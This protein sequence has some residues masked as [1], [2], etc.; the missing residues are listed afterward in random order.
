[1]ITD[2]RA[3]QVA[4]E[5][6]MNPN[7][8]RQMLEHSRS[9]GPAIMERMRRYDRLVGGRRN[10]RNQDDQETSGRISKAEKGDSMPG[11]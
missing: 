9:E 8:A 7:Q 4:R 10:G 1:M 6:G 2:E 5:F 11:G 3:K